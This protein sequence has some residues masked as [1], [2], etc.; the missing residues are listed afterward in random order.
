MK[1]Y[2]KKYTTPEELKL[3]NNAK[4]IVNGEMKEEYF[5]E[6]SIEQWKNFATYAVTFSEEEMAMRYVK[7]QEVSKQKE[8]M[9]DFLSS[10][11]ELFKFNLERDGL[12]MGRYRVYVKN[13]K[14]RLAVKIIGN[15]LLEVAGC[16][17]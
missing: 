4:H 7:Q 14:E 9:K 3:V 11:C 5:D 2:L 12:H 8:M 13:E 10:L 15:Y 16:A 6:N 17:D 1:D